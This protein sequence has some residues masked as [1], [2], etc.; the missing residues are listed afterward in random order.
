MPKSPIWIFLLNW[1]FLAFRSSVTD[2]LP[3]WPTFHHLLIDYT[4]MARMKKDKPVE[5]FWHSQHIDSRD[6]LLIWYRYHSH[7]WPFW[8]PPRNAYSVK[9]IQ[10]GCFTSHLGLSIL[11]YMLFRPEN[12][13]VLLHPEIRITWAVSVTAF[14]TQFGVHGRPSVDRRPRT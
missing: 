3:R 2:L 1:A 14:L 10:E 12:V 8:R 11:P 5:P 9:E 13:G 4:K 6:I 7:F